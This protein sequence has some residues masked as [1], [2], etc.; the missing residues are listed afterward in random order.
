MGDD[1]LH[2]RIALHDREA[3]HR[4]RPFASWAPNLSI[5]PLRG[6]L[7]SQVKRPVL[8]LNGHCREDRA[9]ARSG[10]FGRSRSAQPLKL[11]APFAVIRAAAPE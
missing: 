6:L 8:P 11:S 4:V 9:T 3:D 2:R 5:P 10:G 7:V 1:D